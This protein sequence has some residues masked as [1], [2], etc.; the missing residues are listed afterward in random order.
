[1]KEKVNV[2]DIEKAQEERRKKREKNLS[3]RKVSKNKKENTDKRRRKRKLKVSKRRLT[4][5]LA[6]I[7]MLVFLGITA[8]RIISLKNEQKAV[9][10]EKA[11]KVAEKKRLQREL[12]RINNPE[13]IEQQAMERLRMIRKGETLYVF[14]EAEED[15]S[16]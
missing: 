12:K 5:A 3:K 9:E 8:G 1:M 15:N 2:I 10:E 14:P 16:E 4:L 13:Y 11:A 6:L 7:V